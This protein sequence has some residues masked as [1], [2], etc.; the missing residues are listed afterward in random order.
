MKSF[1][2]VLAALALTASAAAF[3]RPLYS[4]EAYRVGSHPSFN[5]RI[6]TA[7]VS[8]MT[9]VK[10]AF[11]IRMYDARNE[12]VDTTVCRRGDAFGEINCFDRDEVT[13]GFNIPAFTGTGFDVEANSF[14][15]ELVETREDTFG[16][17]LRFDCGR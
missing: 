7:E 3:A 1:N 17:R 14:S 15:F 9:I 12:Q 6:V 13:L 16:G 2:L 10:D 8:S 5:D 11:R 4:C